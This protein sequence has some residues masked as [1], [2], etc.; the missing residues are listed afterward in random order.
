MTWANQGLGHSNNYGD[1][2]SEPISSLSSISLTATGSTTIRTIDV[3]DHV[4]VA[5]NNNDVKCWGGN[6]FGQNS[7]SGPNAHRG[8]DVNEAA[9]LPAISLGS[10]PNPLAV[11]VGENFA[12]YVETSGKHA[13]QVLG[14][15]SQRSFRL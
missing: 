12:L 7:V 2:G 8:D 3:A 4:C 6:L 14:Y 13:N 5:L 10:S 11:E 9:N 1:S 15:F